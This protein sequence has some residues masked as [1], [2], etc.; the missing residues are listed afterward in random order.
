MLC[1]VLTSLLRRKRSGLH[2]EGLQLLAIRIVS[3]PFD[4]VTKQIKDLILASALAPVVG[5]IAPAPGVAILRQNSLRGA[6]P[7]GMRNRPFVAEKC[8][9]RAARFVAARLGYMWRK[10]KQV[11]RAACDRLLADMG[12]V[13]QYRDELVEIGPVLTKLA[14][15][16]D[17]VIMPSVQHFALQQQLASLTATVADHETAILELERQVASLETG[18]QSL[19]TKAGELGELLSESLSVVEDRVKVMDEDLKELLE[20]RTAETTS[21][22]QER[23]VQVE[24]LAFRVTVHV[25]ALDE[26]CEALQKESERVT[27]LE[28]WGDELSEHACLDR[29]ANLE[30]WGEELA[31]SFRWVHRRPGAGTLSSPTTWPRSLGFCV[32]MQSGPCPRWRISCAGHRLCTRWRASCDNGGIGSVFGEGFTVVKGIW[33][34][35]RHWPP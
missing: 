3:G 15:R 17:G 11:E 23:M 25:S 22:V 16:G 7:S 24:R 9:T 29:V 32:V 27:N 19:D 30:C 21:V 1:F 2:S 34:P 28:Q 35:L 33:P 18:V 12:T 6:M 10:S 26:L 20:R 5:N 31:A 13:L 14:G 4:E 8:D